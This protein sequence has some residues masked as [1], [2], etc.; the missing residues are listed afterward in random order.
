MP[1]FNTVD[2]FLDFKPNKVILQ[3]KFSYRLYN[4]EK[5]K[6]CPTKSIATFRSHFLYTVPIYSTT[7]I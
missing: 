1:F 2:F 6:G 4:Y 5:I 3:L 7:G